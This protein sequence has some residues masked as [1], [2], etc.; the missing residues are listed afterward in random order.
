MRRI[1]KEKKE[2][3]VNNRD[4]W[5]QKENARGIEPFG[6]KRARC[7]EEQRFNLT[8]MEGINPISSLSREMLTFSRLNKHNWIF[9]NFGI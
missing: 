1:E 3:K 5:T 8:C 6:K 4:S 2:R 7:S 9:D